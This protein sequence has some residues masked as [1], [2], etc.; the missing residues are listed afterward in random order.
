MIN[1]LK[2]KEELIELLNSYILLND[3]QKIKLFGLLKLKEYKYSFCLGELGT[4]I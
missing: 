1:D 2:N 3:N 4:I